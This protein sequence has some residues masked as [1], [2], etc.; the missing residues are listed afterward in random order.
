MRWVWRTARDDDIV[1]SVDC[2]GGRHRSF[3]VASADLTTWRNSSYLD[4]R[5]W[6][7]TTLTELLVRVR[8]GYLPASQAA[9]IHR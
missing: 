1:F 7:T 2:G 5:D 4:S 9:H 3:Q 6:F 8:P